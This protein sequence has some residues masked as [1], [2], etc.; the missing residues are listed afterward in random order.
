MYFILGDDAI[1]EG[2]INEPTHWVVAEFCPQYRAQFF[3]TR[4]FALYAFKVWAQFKR[5][6]YS[7]FTGGSE[8][9]GFVLVNVRLYMYRT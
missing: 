8:T 1:L 7:L 3:F 9:K 4:A 6:R 2:Y 5:A